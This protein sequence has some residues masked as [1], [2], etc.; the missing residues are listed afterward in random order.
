MSPKAP[1]PPAAPWDR[2]SEEALVGAMLLSPEGLRQGLRGCGAGD[3]WDPELRE[4]YAAIEDLHRSGRPVDEVTVHERVADR[5]GSVGRDR[6]RTLRFSAP[7]SGHAGA[8][9]ETVARYARARNAMELGGELLEAGR[10]TDWERLDALASDAGRRLA[11]ATVPIDTF[12]LVELWELAEREREEPTKPWVIPGCLRVGE[13][14]AYTGGEG[15]GKALATDT[16]IATPNGWATMGD[17]AV[18]DE[19]YAPDGSLTA[20]VGATGVMLGRP[21]YR[22]EFSDGA[23]IVADANHLWATETLDDRE[24]NAADRRRGV[25]PERTTTL[26]TAEMEHSLR[27]R[28]DHCWQYAIPTCAPLRAEDAELPIDPYVL[29]AWLGDGSRGSGGFTCADDG[30]ID[31]IRAAGWEVNRRARQYGWTIRRAALLRSSYRTPDGQRMRGAGLAGRL[32]RLGVLF[33]KR[34]PAVY[35]RASVEQRVALLQ[36]LMDTD[37][38]I[39]LHRGKAPKC[40]FSVTDEG[41]ASDTQELLLTLGVKTV[42]RKGPAVLRGI[43]VGTRYRLGFYPWFQP[44]RLRRKAERWAEPRTA[45]ARMRYVTA[46]RPIPSVPVRCIKVASPDGLYLAGRELVATHNSTWLRQMG[47]CVSAGMH[48]VTGLVE[49][50]GMTPHRTLTVDCQEDEVDMAEELTKLR[51][52]LEHHYRPGLYHAV[53]MRGGIDLLSPRGQRVFEG[54]LERTRPE[55]VLMGPVV[56]IFRAPQ[57]RTRYGEDVVDELTDVL[58]DWMDRYGFALV[59]EGHAGNERTTDEDWRIRGSSVWRSW[60]AFSHALKVAVTVETREAEVIR[61][62]DDRYANRAW[63]TRMFGGTPFRLPWQPCENDYAAVLRAVGRP[64]LLGEAEQG[65]LDLPGRP[66]ERY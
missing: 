32:R 13:V 60:P 17:L 53:A 63:P 20:V 41:L 65:G 31:E 55:L 25:Q 5:G 52:A 23:A 10:A 2:D 14:I 15:K 42:M 11:P 7:L 66:G 64:D 29:G 51:R 50:G 21:C 33:T 38:T 19:V 6:I 43:E 56:K 62:R 12:D 59:L 57:G 34:I 4:V 24:R 39:M 22:V 61:A 45:R 27:A 28:G 8:Y 30:I 36:G 46:V 48:P 54:L 26:T 1:V 18:G 37:G 16:P 44:F 47:A 35:L 49:I 3:L 40:E 58:D 9:A